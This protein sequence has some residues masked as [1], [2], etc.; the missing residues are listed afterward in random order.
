MVK[1]WVSH[2]ELQTEA[3]LV[4]MNDQVKSYQVARLRSGH[5]YR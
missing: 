4:V 1:C 5:L 2:S 3:K